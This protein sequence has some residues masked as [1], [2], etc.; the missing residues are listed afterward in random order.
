M[1]QPLIEQHPPAEADGCK[2]QLNAFPNRDQERVGH[3]MISVLI[4]PRDATTI[5]QEV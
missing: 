3:A 4:V 1:L 5:R 2:V